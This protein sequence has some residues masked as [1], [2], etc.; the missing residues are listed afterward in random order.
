VARVLAVD[1]D[2]LVEAGEYRSPVQPVPL[3]VRP[4]TRTL[5]LHELPEDRFEDLLTDVMG[6]LH[7]DGHA[8]RFGG[9]GHRQFGIDI[10]VSADGTNIATG[11]CKRHREFGPKAVRDAIGA[12]TIMAPRNYLFLSR[13]VATPLARAEATK[14]SS[15]E[16]WD[17]EDISRHIRNLPRDQAVRIVD[18]YFPAHRESFL[19]VV[20]PGP[21]LLAEEHFAVTRSTIFNHQWSLAGR[22]GEL[23][24]LAAAAY[25]AD[26]T[27]AFLIGSGGQGKTRLLKALA[28]EAPAGV[29]VRILPGEA[30]VAA[31]DFELLPPDA[32][33]TMIIDDAHELDR[34]ASVVSGIWRRNPNANVILATRPYGQRWLK[35]DL[36]RHSLLPAPLIEIAL[37]DLDFDDSVQLALEALGGTG[38]L[39]LARR[40]AQVTSDSPLATVVGGVLIQQGQLDPAELE[41]SEDVR[42]HIMR[43]FSD[44]LVKDPLADDPPTRRAV[45]DAISAM[46]PFRMDE[47]SARLSLARVVGKP[48]DELQRHLRSLE[49]AGVLRRRGSALRIVPDLLGDVILSEAALDSASA[50]GTGYLERIEP[51]I[52]GSSVEHLLVNVSRVDWQVHNVRSD[53]PSLV[54][55][56]WDALTR[57]MQQADLLHRRA[58]VATLAKAAYFQPERALTLTRW[59]IDNPTDRLDGEHGEWLGLLQLD[60]RTVLESLPTA[61]KPAALT[62]ETL[63]VAL[64]QLW[65][66]AQGDDRPTNPNPN[67]PLR[68]LCEL[69]EFG[70]TKPIWFNDLIVDV[71]SGWFEDGQRLSPF[72][73][74]EPMLATEGDDST[75]RGNTITFTP[76]GLNPQSVM[77]IRQRIIDLAFE[78]LESGDLRRSGAAAKLLKSAMQFPH[79][80]FGRAVSNAERD[81]WTPGIVATIDRLGTRAASGGLDPAVLVAV[82]DALFWHDSF[83]SGPAHDSAQRAIESLP[84]DV[85]VRLG[86]LVHD[87]W[88]R[89]VR[90]RGDSYE[91]MEARRVDLIQGVVNDLADADDQRV[92]EMLVDRL[93]ADRE[94]YGLSGGFPGPLVEGLIRAR[95]TVGRVMLDRIQSGAEPGDFDSILPIVLATYAT[96][97]P[98]QALTY[99]RA[100]SSSASPDRRQAAAQAIGWNR[101]LRDLH[102]GELDLLIELA[103]GDDVSVRRNV[104]R[105]AQL[106]ARV[107]KAEATRL[108]AAVRFGDSEALADD[109]FMSFRLAGDIS[110]HDF[111]S[112]ELRRIREDLVRLPDIGEYSI[113]E[114]LSD[115]S[116]SHPEWVLGVL[117]ERIE[118]AEGL[119]ST[120]RYQ[121]LPFAWENRLRIRETTAYVRALN[122]ILAW[123]AER[124]EAWPRHKLGAELF[125]AVAVEFDDQVLEVLSMALSGGNRES[126][127]AVAAVLHEAPRT[128]VWDR[129]DFVCLALNAANRLGD[130]VLKRMTGGL[131]AATISGVRMGT[132]G[133]AFPET[134]EQRERSLVVARSLETGSIEKRFYADLAAAADSDIRRETVD[135]MFADGREW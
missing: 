92:V 37:E 112:A 20:A 75:L 42:F 3:P 133:Q 2:A 81:S 76:F 58:L 5:P 126:A 62:V 8:S 14:Y 66:L 21:W 111:S 132:P 73:V 48:Y 71:V 27:L 102:P 43:G 131:W 82:R 38:S 108:L 119:D 134:L 83:G 1:V 46:Q 39:P 98:A 79:G 125:A 67:H 120:Q 123:V 127:L 13:L 74:L 35:E 11:Q 7:P 91:A 124:P 40:L 64:A 57:E 59:L 113:S 101:G 80:R 77:R 90:D 68:V 115:R 104:V 26:G 128:L 107:R 36:A 9:R 30:Q 84:A 49:N 99:V 61:I 122:D 50:R 88:G 60:Y 47:E 56:L 103:A 105:A 117:R 10:L 41:Q 116:A 72:D 18:T 95:P 63:P 34:V 15:W 96:I 32:K 44:A 89:L 78:E 52:G 106:L 55:S 17:G 53:A 121:A 135:D 87:G 12:V 4:L 31:A 19:G 85:E 70:V 110:W 109:F 100:L 86:L 16:L 114:A 6:T 129:S 45:L 25:G 22:T 51:L 24:S 118:R 94:I 54:D 97:D 23:E 33:L 65:E 69:A 28:E 93:R 130:A 29:N